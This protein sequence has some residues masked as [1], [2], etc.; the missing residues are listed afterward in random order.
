MMTR[1]LLLALLLSLSARTAAAQGSD[2]GTNAP[3]LP[4]ALA[5]EVVDPAVVLSEVQDYLE[6]RVPAMPALTSAKD[7]TR[8]ADRLRADILKQVVLRS[9]CL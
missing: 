7:W 5:R 1:I 8:Y 3:Y 9:S 2:T 4:A 6:P